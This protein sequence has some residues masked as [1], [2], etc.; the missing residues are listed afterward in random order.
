MFIVER[1]IG[2]STFMIILLFSFLLIYNGKL[3]YKKALRLFLL[4]I[5]ILAFFYIPPQ[6]EDLYRIHQIMDGMQN[7]SWDSALNNM[8]QT[9][10]PLG[11]LLFFLAAKVR[12]YGLVPAIATYITYNNIFTILFDSSSKMKINNNNKA[13]LFLFAIS[14]GMFGVLISNIRSLLSISI[15]MKCIYEEAVTNK[16][17]IKNI[18]RYL[19]AILFHPI[20]ILVL[21]CWFFYQIFQN[22]SIRTIY[23]ILIIVSIIIS[24][25]IFKDYYNMAI[26]KYQNYS[27]ENEY[28]NIFDFIKILLIDLILVYFANIAKRIAKKNSSSVIINISKFIIFLVT[29][30]IVLHE[31]NILIRVSYYISVLS[32]PLLAY[33]FSNKNELKHKRS[34][35]AIFMIL[36]MVPLLLSIT[37]G[38]L[39]S[40]KFLLFN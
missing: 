13:W 17:F 10:Y 25:F 38:H 36:I 27:T 12:I 19:I 30:I 28:Y 18:L 37:R 33:I 5:T 4:L 11:Y 32:L 35:N 40:Y 20:S 3:S 7:S 15:I 26:L 21:G 29:V 34:F 22:K 14:N 23:K 2:I 1:I 31:Y 9:S 6:G 8:F 24:F 39:S 16:K